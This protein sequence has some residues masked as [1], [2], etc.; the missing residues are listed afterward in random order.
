VTVSGSAEVIHD[1]VTRVL[2]RLRDN[3]LRA[4]TKVYNYVPGQPLFAPS[5]HFGIPVAPYGQPH[6]ASMVQHGL[7]AYGVQQVSEPPSTQKIAIP[8]LC[9][10]GVIGKGGSVIRDLRAQ[11]GTNISI[12]DP[13]T[14]PNERVVTITGTPQGIQTAIYLIRQLVEQYPP[15]PQY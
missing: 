12:A 2:Q 3:P 4:G 8:T 14:N 11:S 6:M 13:D 15:G 5:P 1:A 9:A 10:G 7:S